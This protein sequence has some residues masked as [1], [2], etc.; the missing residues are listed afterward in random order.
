MFLDKDLRI[1]NFTPAIAKMFPL[2]EGDRDRPLS[3]IVSQ[4]I[5]S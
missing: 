2:R 3:H 5:D 1:K 4:L